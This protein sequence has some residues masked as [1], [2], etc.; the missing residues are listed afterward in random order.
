ML[1]EVKAT[2]YIVG[3]DPMQVEH[4]WQLMYIG[5]FYRGGP[6]LGSAISGIDQ[7]LWDIRGKVMDLPVYEMLGGPED[8]VLDAR[9]GP[10]VVLQGIAGPANERI[11][12]RFA[13]EVELAGPAVPVQVPEVVLVGGVGPAQT[14]LAVLAAAASGVGVVE[15]LDVHGRFLSEVQKP[16]SLSFR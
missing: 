3:S 15:L 4:L 12:H 2:F 9:H 13:H 14:V 11:D 1:F 5:S 8:T 7:A 10:G 16:C 6:V